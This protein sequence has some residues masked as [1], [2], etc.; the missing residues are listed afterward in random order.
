MRLKRLKRL[1]RLNS[2]RP[3]V[4]GA[5][6]P[7]QSVVGSGGLSVLECSANVRVDCLN[8]VSRSRLQRIVKIEVAQASQEASVSKNSNEL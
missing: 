7:A 3:A 4:S 2:T 8:S 1:K 6:G 5:S